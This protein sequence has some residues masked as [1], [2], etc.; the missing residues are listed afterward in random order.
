MLR[1]KSATKTVFSEL[2][3]K[4]GRSFKSWFKLNWII[5]TITTSMLSNSF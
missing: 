4:W 1:T 5:L 3:V 2:M